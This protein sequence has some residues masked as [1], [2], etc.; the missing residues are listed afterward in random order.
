MNQLIYNFSKMSNNSDNVSQPQKKLKNAF[1]VL[2]KGAEKLIKVELETASTKAKTTFKS[3]QNNKKRKELDEETKISNPD[4]DNSKQRKFHSLADLHN[5]LASKGSEVE[6]SIDYNKPPNSDDFSNTGDSSEFFKSS[7][8]RKKKIIIPTNPKKENAPCEESNKEN[9]IDFREGVSQRSSYKSYST[10]FREEFIT[11]Y[12]QHGLT[13]AC[14]YKGVTIDVGSKWVKNYKKQGLLGLVD[15]RCQNSGV[16]NKYLDIYVLD[17]F[18][19]KRAKGIMVNGLL[20]KAIALQA[21]PSIKPENFMASNGWLSRFLERNQIVR[22]KTTHQ[23]QELID[24]LNLEMKYYLD[25]LQGLYD[26]DRELIYLNFDETPI[27]Y[28]LSSDYT[29]GLKGEKSISSLSHP[30]NKERATVTLAVASNGDTLPPLVTFKYQY[31]GKGTRDFPKK[32]ENFKNVSKPYMVRFTES[33]FNKEQNIIDYI[34]KVILQWKAN[35]NQD[36]V[37]ILDQAKCHISKKVTD[38]LDKLR[39]TYLF[40]PAG[41]THLFQPLDVLLN[42]PFKDSMRS[43]Y[44]SWLNNQITKSDTRII[45]PP[46]VDNILDWTLKSIQEMTSIQVKESFAVTA[47][48]GNIKEL[49]LEPKLSIKLNILIES[50]LLENEDSEPEYQDKGDEMLVNIALGQELYLSKD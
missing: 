19:K 41:G 30:N 23:A 15:K 20:L 32:Y 27:M 49:F 21:L 43:F 14:L 11:H 1:D 26:S 12:L 50:Y 13:R 46:T 18:N 34:N 22:R 17:E 45:N 25:A 6:M 3:N 47:I 7:P 31:G 37:I 48:N 44:L 39:L 29:Y 35:I 16:V 33:G 28:D 9:K 2:K 42:K 5:P 8:S 38:H 40:I 36:I 10:E 4:P 24:N